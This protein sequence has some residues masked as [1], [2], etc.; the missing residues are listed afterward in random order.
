M[1][2]GGGGGCAGD[3]GG[4][5]GAMIMTSDVSTVSSDPAK[6]SPAKK[7]LEVE[8]LIAS[9]SATTAASRTAFDSPEK[10]AVTASEAPAIESVI[11]LSLTPAMPASVV[12]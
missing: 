2:G 1:G 9:E 5:D 10:V 12:L 3:G 4:G 7:P 6:V 8:V 11:E